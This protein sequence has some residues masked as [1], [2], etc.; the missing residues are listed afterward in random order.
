M[1]GLYLGDGAP[2]PG[3]ERCLGAVDHML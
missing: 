3:Q 1:L 2:D